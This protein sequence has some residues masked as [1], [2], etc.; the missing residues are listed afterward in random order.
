MARGKDILPPV[1]FQGGV[2]ANIGIRAAFE[3]LGTPVYVPII[4]ALWAP[5]SVLLAQENMSTA[6]TSSSFQFEAAKLDYEA[7]SFDCKA[8]QTN[9]K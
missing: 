7:S 1:V 5:G 6:K 2:A 9:V 8:A 4:T 3:S